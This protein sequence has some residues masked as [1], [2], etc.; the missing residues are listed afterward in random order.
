MMTGQI[1]GG[2]PV[3]EAAHYQILIMYLISTC[4]F[5]AI[6]F[7]MFIIYRVAFD[8]GTHVL[9]TDRFIEVVD[10][11]QNKKV[12][13]MQT[14]MGFVDNCC[15]PMRGRSRDVASNSETQ[16]LQYGSSKDTNTIKILTREVSGYDSKPM[17][18][19]ANL[20]FSVQKSHQKKS[21]SDPDAT[22]LHQSPSS[23]APEGTNNQLQSQQRVLCTNLT[24]SFKK[25]EIGIVRGPSGCGKTTLLRVLAGLTPLDDGDVMTSG[26][27]LSA[28]YG[29][30]DG[31][32]LGHDIIQWRTTVRYVTQNKADLPGTPRDFIARVASFHISTFEFLSEDEM[33]LQTMSYLD[34]WGMGGSKRIEYSASLQDDHHPYLDKEWKTLSGGESQRMLLAIA[35]ASRATILLLDEAT[36]GLDNEME[37]IVENSVVEYSTKNGA[38]VL[39]VTHSDDI[40]ERLLASHC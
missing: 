16:P 9:R 27:S 21:R 20:A 31:N 15:C 35:M 19:I 3:T 36:S 37:K 7:N 28:C 10:T 30:G 38:V 40:A 33:L 29:R 6:C 2:S 24:A 32:G 25:G 1:L 12:G 14:M 23:S 34:Q 13:I 39:W 5:I 4:T 18:R 26:L 11:K 8:A 17:F 22:S